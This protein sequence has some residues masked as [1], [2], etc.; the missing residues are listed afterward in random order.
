MSSSNSIYSVFFKFNTD[1]VLIVTENFTLDPD[2]IYTMKSVH[3][4]SLS[5]ML[6]SRRTDKSKSV[7]FDIFSNEKRS[8]KSYLCVKVYLTKTSSTRCSYFYLSQYNLNILILVAYKPNIFP[9]VY[10]IRD[11]SLFFTS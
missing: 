4:K 11:L 3:N 1:T 10:R 8:A 9:E 6:V 2:V 7:I 5:E